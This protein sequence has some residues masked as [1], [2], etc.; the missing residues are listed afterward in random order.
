MLSNSLS[1]LFSHTQQ[2]NASRYWS[3]FEWSIHSH[4]YSQRH[5]LQYMILWW[6]SENV[7]RQ[8]TDEILQIVRFE[9][10]ELRLAFDHDVMSFFSDCYSRLKLVDPAKLLY[11]LV[12]SLLFQLKLLNKLW[13]RWIHIVPDSPPTK[14]HPTNKF[15]SSRSKFKI[16][17]AINVNHL[18]KILNY[19]LFLLE[20]G[21]RLKV[22]YT[23]WHKSK[24]ATCSSWWFC[25]QR[26][27]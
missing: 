20:I 24:S 11:E 22:I 19:E 17:N 4:Q 21:W 10:Q 12:Y 2:T 18:M 14:C 6:I 3:K 5:G 16:L 26:P 23:F 8:M 27:I 7:K 13:P 9:W 25:F 15:S 1:T